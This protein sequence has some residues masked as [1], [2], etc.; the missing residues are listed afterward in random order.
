MDIGGTITIS[1][2]VSTLITVIGGLFLKNFF[3]NYMNQKGINLA[4]KEDIAE[5]TNKTEE[6]K[7]F[8]LS[9]LE[10]EKKEINIEIEKV[11]LEQN[12]QYKN[13]ELFIEKRHESYPELFKLIELSNGYI[14]RLRG[15]RRLLTFDN[16]SKLDIETYMNE[17]LFTNY[18]IQKILQIWDTNRI[19]AIQTLNHRL[20]KVEYEEAFEKYIEAAD[21]YFFNQLYLSESVESICN[22]LKDDLHAL[23]V[24]YDNDNPEPVLQENRIL[25][26]R[27]DA[28]REVLKHT[29]RKELNSKGNN[30][31]H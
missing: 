1:V 14:R 30:S 9:K 23:W 22:K 10:L 18:D 29:M 25:I 2:V 11:K 6:V 15:F 3:P 31:K 5:I 21:Y 8:F 7:S 20:R 4:T 24:N 16:V 27:I 19:E 13:Y 17:K 12:Q 26:E 28:N